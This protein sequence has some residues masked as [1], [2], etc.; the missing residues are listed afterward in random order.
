MVAFAKRSKNSKLGYFIKENQLILF[1]IIAIIIKQLLLTG[2]PIF[3][4]PGAGHDDRMMVNMADSLIKGQWLGSYSELTLVKGVF[5]PLFLAINALFGIPYSIAVPGFYALG[6]V[7]FVMGVKKLFKNEL[8]LYIIFFVLIFNPISFANETFVRVYRNSLV[9]AQVLMI[10]GCMFAVYLN[11]FEKKWMLAGWAIGGGLGLASLWHSREDGIWIIPLVLGVIIITWLTIF[12]KKELQ[13]KEKVKR[14]LIVGSP[15]V[16]LLVTTIIISSINYAYYGVYTTNELNDSNY[17]KTIKLIYSVQASEEIHNVS[18]PLSSMEKICQVSPTLSG[19]SDEIAASMDHWSWYGKDVEKREVEDGWFF[20]SLRE[21]VANSGYYQNA[22]MA[23]NFYA[24]VNSELEAAF[25]SGKLEKRNTMPSALMSPWRDNYWG[26]L[27]QAFLVTIHY[28][29]GFE[30]LKTSVLESIDDGRNGIRLF[31]RV[32]NNLAQYPGETTKWNDQV[33]I[34]ILN[35]IQSIYQLCGVLVFLLSGIAYGCIT[36]LILIKKWR[37]KYNLLDFWLVLSGLLFSAFV[38]AIGVAYTEISAYTA[39]S[40]WYL[41]GAYPLIVA[42][43][44]I[45]LYKIIE[46]INDSR[47]NKKLNATEKSTQL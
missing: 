42:F 41:A 19:I 3:A 24:Q 37:K 45:S 47:L 25:E 2:L 39:I 8:P 28:V 11:R 17:T 6:C 35:G 26:E 23:N 36:V 31:E 38:L 13:S 40:Y 27:P 44:A 14:S 18:V 1:M 12:L 15:I 46:M 4:Y 9:A 32:T 22:Q 34:Q 29:A 43:N 10:S 7:V 5:F 21:A 16:I 33:R 30:S 20:W